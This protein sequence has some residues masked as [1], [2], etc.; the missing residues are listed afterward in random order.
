MPPISIKH[1]NNMRHLL[2]TIIAL[3]S[4]TASA[5]NGGYKF[6]IT[7]DGSAPAPVAIT[8]LAGETTDAISA[9][10]TVNQD[11]STKIA[12]NRGVSVNHNMTGSATTAQYT[13]TVSGLPA[14]TK[15]SGIILGTNAMDGSGN[16]QAATNERTRPITITAAEGTAASTTWANAVESD[17]IKKTITERA[18]LYTYAQPLAKNTYNLDTPQTLNGDDLT[19]TITIATT[20]AATE[21]HKGLYAAVSEITLATVSSDP[22]LPITEAITGTSGTGGRYTPNI[23]LN[24]QTIS[25]GQSSTAKTI[26]Q[27]QT[28]QKFTVTTGETLNASFDY[29]GAWMHTYVF[30]DEDNN[31]FS[32]SDDD[33]LNNVLQKGTNIDLRTFSYYKEYNSAG[34]KQAD[35][36][37]WKNL[38]A[39]N[40]PTTPGTYRM[41]FMVAWNSIKPEGY[42]GIA[43]H[44]GLICDVML[45][46]KAPV[47]TPADP[48]SIENLTSGWYQIQYL[49]GTGAVSPSDA[50]K[51]LATSNFNSPAV[52]SGTKYDLVV[53]DDNT[54]L[55][56]L[57]YITD[58]GE[59]GS[60]SA[61]TKL[62][63][64]VTNEL[65][66]ITL[67]SGCA[68][69]KG[70]SRATAATDKVGI[71]A[72]DTDKTAWRLYFNNGANF[73]DVFYQATPHFLGAGAGQYNIRYHLYKIDIEAAY[74]IYTVAYD[75]A[76]TG[77]PLLTYNKTG[78]TGVTELIA[79]GKIFVKKGETPTTDQ[80][81]SAQ[82]AGANTKVE[83]DTDAKTIT[84]KLAISPE[85]L[86]AA[87]T[88]AQAILATRGVG[89]PKTE[90]AAYTALETAI[91]NAEAVLT[92]P[93]VEALT[94]ITDAL[95]TYYTTTDIET[96]VQGGVY[97]FKVMTSVASALGTPL[98]YITYADAGI[99]V[100]DGTPNDQN[101]IYCALITTDGK[102]LF[103]FQD[104]DKYFIWK[105][106][107]V[108]D[109]SDKGYIEATERYTSENAPNSA[110]F[111]FKKITGSSVTTAN[112]EQT[113]GYVGVMA[114]GR[115]AAATN[116]P[117]FVIK[118]ADKSF[119]AANAP[120]FNGS[121]TSAFALE[122]VETI[123]VGIDNTTA[124][125][126]TANA[127]YN[128][129]GQRVTKANSGLYII[130]GKKHLG[131]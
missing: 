3:L 103:Q 37:K 128:I 2:L 88:K 12:A 36:N 66:T 11:I 57:I 75:A 97:R 42:A 126:N 17:L 6:T 45:E 20:D 52:L 106:L 38:P 121:Y 27:N 4:L 105:G 129:S 81:T 101:L 1:T 117:Y 67:P 53:T 110:K 30:I 127:I 89:Y 91:S 39:F 70:G 108:G 32:A 73:A 13:L 122:Y 104:N 26:W 35:G 130:N 48:T 19:I 79:N 71:D 120:F 33:I 10:F 74:D 78:Y 41:R 9:T 69:G 15:I 21:H 94:G 18:E 46:V 61:N 85:E 118:D 115:Q 43:G 90:S 62:S 92:T 77:T 102:C 107:N 8:S 65:T 72:P 51:F 109:N 40:A 68:L 124:A 31:G 116:T 28:T 84:V 24:N 50:N 49:G 87:I 34:E 5:Q 58:L 23:T 29:K 131:K 111:S 112:A 76:I 16:M 125:D 44:G 7:R 47:E 82:S 83:I 59:Q 14:G 86:Q 22:Y 99:T 113:F 123:T 95:Q 100:N 96:P 114:D 56:T 63:P 80:F 119:N 55:N 98:G 60:T 64:A 25:T 54:A 93:T